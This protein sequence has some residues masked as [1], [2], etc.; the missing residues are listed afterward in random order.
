MT[1]TPNNLIDANDTYDTII[2][3]GGI[4]GAGIFRDLSI[5]GVECLLID[6]KDFA[7]QTSQT[8]SKMLHGGIRYLE[9][10]NFGLVWEALHEKNLWLQ[11]APHL[12]KELP[13]HMP[14][15]KES[16]HPM[17]MIKMGLMLYD[18]L[19]SY[20][21]SPHKM[22][23]K[24]NTSNALPRLKTKDLKGCGVYYD[25]IV[26]DSKLALET[27]YDGLVNEKCH[28]LNYTSII[29]FT[30]NS[31][32]TCTGELTDE[33]TK[34]TK[35]ITAKNVVFATGPFTDQLLDCLKNINWTPQMVPARGIHLWLDHKTLPIKYPMILM[36]KDGRVVFVIPQKGWVLVGTTEEL[37][38]GDL[39]DLVARD[40][41]VDYLLESLKEYFPDVLIEKTDILS[42]FAGIR[43]LVRAGKSVDIHNTSRHHKIIKPFDN[44]Y[45]IMGGKLT[46]YRLM[47]HKITKEI[48]T[49]NGLK[50][51]ADLT[52]VP[53]RRPSVI[54]PF[55]PLSEL[56][57]SDILKIV[58]SEKVKT[59]QDL[60]RRR[61][62]LPARSHLKT[63][64][65]FDK[66]F[67]PLVPE[68]SKYIKITEDDVKNWK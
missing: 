6:K 33:L 45:V 56:S 60:V 51:S 68:L 15:F 43:P 61:L 8:S 38:E 58:K 26:D 31:D 53:F 54:G 27:I 5:H 46:T 48:V 52:K 18:F 13:F 44:T 50:F 24:Q 20:K 64:Q 47:G 23:S 49:K 17:W 41:E 7:S 62:G 34:E 59:F 63:Q 19:S 10:Y 29:G 36:T 65:N 2:V 9:T 35:K 40:D 16:K 1:K 14:F 11:L 3:G 42:T 39:F 67:L 55:D 25:V 30:H 57:E 22:L 12:C 37:A 32:G 4:V 28:A 21:N 66:F